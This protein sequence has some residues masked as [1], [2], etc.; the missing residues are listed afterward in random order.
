MYVYK[1]RY[2]V[3]PVG[4]E[5]KKCICVIQASLAM[6]MLMYVFVYMYVCMNMYLLPVGRE[7]AKCIRVVQAS[8]A[9][10]M[11]IPPAGLLMSMIRAKY[12]DIFE[13]L[14]HVAKVNAGG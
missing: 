1:Y 3:I 12:P 2:S 14:N 6:M 8:L 4:R 11:F 9:M 13:G 7:S 5:I 10:I